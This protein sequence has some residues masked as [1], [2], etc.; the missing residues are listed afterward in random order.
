MSLNK[1]MSSPV[2]TSLRWYA[3]SDT[4]EVV[5]ECERCSVE[6]RLSKD[7]APEELTFEHEADCSWMQELEEKNTARAW[8]LTEALANVLDDEPN[9]ELA[10]CALGTVVGIVCNTLGEQSGSSPTEVVARFAGELE[11]RI[12][13]IS[14]L[15]SQARPRDE[16][17]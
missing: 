12:V 5:A 8:D 11:R 17:A 16:A 10:L 7:K 6:L 14:K 3:D 2:A 4:N 13:D 1:F 15:L 9:P